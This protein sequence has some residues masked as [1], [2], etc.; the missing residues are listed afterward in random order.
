MSP[1]SHVDEGAVRKGEF[2][3][4]W[5]FQM[6]ITRAIKVKQPSE[7]NDVF[8]FFQTQLGTTR[9]ASQ[10]TEAKLETLM[11]LNYLDAR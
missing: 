5:S 1:I 11:S 7:W 4:S 8:K 10:M 6:S 9:R 3:S 2:S